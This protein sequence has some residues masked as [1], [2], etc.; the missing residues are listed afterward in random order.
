MS[1]LG[2]DHIVKRHF[3]N[4]PNECG[5]IIKAWEMPSEIVYYYSSLA[6]KQ[7]VEDDLHTRI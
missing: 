1:F 5:W 2:V 4:I 6:S 7:A 3:T